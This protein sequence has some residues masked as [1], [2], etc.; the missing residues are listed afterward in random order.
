MQIKEDN[1]H[2]YG[3]VFGGGE[4]N[5]SGSENYDWNFVSVTNGITLNIDGTDYDTNNH[6]FII[7]GSICWF[8]CIYLGT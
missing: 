2:I 8:K 7:N 4:S 3:T 6:T 1:I 5:A